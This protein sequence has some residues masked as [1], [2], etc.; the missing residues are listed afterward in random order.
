[1]NMTSSEQG[2]QTMHTT[3]THVMKK[4]V[5]VSTL[6]IAAAASPLWAEEAMQTMPG[7]DSGTMQNEEG[8]SA[9]KNSDTTS[10]NA[11]SMPSGMQG[12]NNAAPPG[13]T[14]MADMRDPHAYSGGY[15]LDSGPYAQKGPRQ[16]RLADEQN[17]G[18]L[19]V[20]Q[21]ETVRTSNNTTAAYDLQ[22]WFGRDY[23]RALLR[24]E[25]SYD[26]RLEEASTELLWSHA[27]STFWDSVLGV[28]YDSGDAPDRRWLA[29]GIQGLA[30]YWFE[31]AVTGYAGEDGRSALRLVASYEV[32]FT[33][34]LILQ[35]QLEL[36]F[37]GKDDSAQGIG[38]GLSDTVAGL[39]LRYEIRREFAPYVGIEWSDQ[40][41]GT[42]DYSTTSGVDT[43]ETR[44]VAGVRFWF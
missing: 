9:M 40:Y 35:P 20:E 1:M 26:K 17:F 33:Q 22:A 34:R 16:L 14:G 23:D 38:S 6:L 18:S 31:T 7:M 44:L 37:Y 29:F 12:M 15:T 8:M 19:L 25:G 3:M 28:R 36:N 2:I 11:G 10:M 13:G 41:G 27:L 43:S 39:R 42:A 4:T 30:P 24:A 32:L 21:L 5:A